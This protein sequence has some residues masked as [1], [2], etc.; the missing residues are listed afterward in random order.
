VSEQNENP[1]LPEH[2]KVVSVV[3]SKDYTAEDAERRERYWAEFRKNRQE[4]F[5][6]ALLKALNNDHK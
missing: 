2:R 3:L 5:D 4:A 6:K 1:K